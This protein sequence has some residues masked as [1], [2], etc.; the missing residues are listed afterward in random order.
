M[1]LYNSL[2]HKKEKDVIRLPGQIP[3]VSGNLSSTCFDADII[4]VD[5]V[6]IARSVRIVYDVLHHVANLFCR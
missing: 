5:F 6:S 4:S 3:V 1:Q 2:S